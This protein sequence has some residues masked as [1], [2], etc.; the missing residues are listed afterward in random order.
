MMR[1]RLATCCSKETVTVG[2]KKLVID[3]KVGDADREKL[4]S[5]EQDILATSMPIAC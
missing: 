2:S 4:W 3:R 5:E 1:Y